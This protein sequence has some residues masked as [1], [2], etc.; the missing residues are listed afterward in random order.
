MW[1][2]RPQEKAFSSLSQKSLR[3]AP[4]QPALIEAVQRNS[5]G[6]DL[7]F[8]PGDKLLSIN[9]VQPRD[10]IDYKYLIA[11]E[12]LELEVL[13]DD[14]KLHKIQLD[15]NLDDD[16]GLVFKEVL[17]DGLKQCNNHCS[18]CFI[19]Q[20]PKGHR[21]TLYLKDDDYRMS[22]L[23]GS[24]LT[25]TNLRQKDWQ[26]IEQQRLS[27][28]FVSIHSTDSTLRAKLLKNNR[29]GLIMKQIKWF[30]ERKLQLHAQI[31]VCPDLNDSKN[32][33]KTL[34]D[35]YLYAQG[36]WPTV[37]S[38]A[39]VP[40]GLTRFRPSDDSLKPV[41]KECANKVIRLVEKLQKTYQ[42]SIGRRFAWL[43][44]E[45]Y[46]LSHQPLPSR[47]EYEDLPQEE[48]GVGSIRSFLE[49]MEKA[50]SKLPERIS[51]KKNSSWVVG[52]LVETALGPIAERMNQ[53]EGLSLKLF[54]L[55]SPYWGKENV[56]TGLLT[57]QDII[58]GLEEKELGE[59]LLLPSIMLK[60]GEPTFLDDMTVETVEKTLK[61]TI[62]IIS[63]PDEFVK[64][65]I[66][67]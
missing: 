55:K 22:F 28:L 3:E 53:I 25:L 35:L 59:E 34:N 49:N 47:G 17:F 7:G 67:D 40:V 41:D 48:N 10:L 61:I 8:Q 36:D 44:D 24:Y 16:L 50:T 51:K 21:N 5:I 6:K 64:A 14:D 45:W 30:S 42:S 20:Q 29:A 18:F 32:L 38:A 12:Q 9:G 43:S 63:S 60:H 37:L 11:E 13:D 54:G 65:L 52:K 58:T 46:L 26:R 27:P 2:E 4:V 31:V 23:Y 15:K 33:E 56:V 62:K 39:V 19:D 66:K 57:G 1:N